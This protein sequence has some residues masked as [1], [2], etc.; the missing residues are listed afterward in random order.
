MAGININRTTS[1]VSLPK[2][3][4]SEIITLMEQ[5]SAVQ[6]L[7][8][9]IELPGG[10][11]NVPVM[12]GLPTAG[13][14][15]QE[16]DAKPVSTPSF[17]S[18]EMTA[19]T[20]AVVVPFSN[21]F[22]RDANA[23]YNECVRVLPQALAVKFDETVFASSNPPG[24]NFDQIGGATVVKLGPK[25]GDVKENTYAGLVDAY[26]AIAGDGG[27]LDGWA[28]SSAGKGLLLAQVDGNGRP[29]LLDSIINGTSIP[30]ILGE[31]VAYTEAAA[32]TP[33]VGFAGDW[34]H[35]RWGT[36]EG[37]KISMS[38]GA[39]EDGTITVGDDQ[40][41]GTTEVP[42]VISLWSRNMF[43]LRA[44]IEIG[45]RV[46]NVNKFRKLTSTARS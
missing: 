30:M 25:P 4:A 41:T 32:S 1:G 33:T 23:L 2:S 3:V 27:R 5:T 19:Y 10:G 43:A 7:A 12:T 34:S 18:K 20:L 38:E 15:T 29:L 14:V 37:I 16:T 26:K 40:N 39:I 11:T 17:T 31:R 36:V 6:Q 13:W 21:Q 46:S 28:L 44:E 35:S 9:R 24:S 42:K 22:R 8:T 45:F